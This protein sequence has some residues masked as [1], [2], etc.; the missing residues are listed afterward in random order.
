MKSE[1][2]CFSFEDLKQSPAQTSAWDGVRN[3]QARNLLR[4][5]IQVG[6]GVLFY[7]SSIKVPAIAGLARVVRG[8]YPDPTAWDPTSEHF[9]PKSRPEHPAWFMVDVRYAADVTPPITR[10]DLKVHP[11]LSK[12][13]VL[14][15]GNRLSVMPVAQEEWRAIL[16][17]RKMRDPLAV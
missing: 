16:S 2:A 11:V 7:H 9:D 17:L 14:K 3:Y 12:M 5:E 13:G 4:D 10:D 1:P 15:R 8:G 6:D